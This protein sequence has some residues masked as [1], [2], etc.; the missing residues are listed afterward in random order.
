ML[1]DLVSRVPL[2][3]GRLCDG[4]KHHGL[5]GHVVVAQGGRR[6]LPLRRQG[7]LR[8]QGLRRQRRRQERSDEVSDVL[9]PARPRHQG[10]GAALPAVVAVRQV[11]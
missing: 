4:R 3:S 1:P 10:D 5:F 8:R 6:R 9:R 7:R 2:S 11:R